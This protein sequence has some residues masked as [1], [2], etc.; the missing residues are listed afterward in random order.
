MD[1]EQAIGEQLKQWGFSVEKIPES[2]VS[3]QKRPDYKAWT[4]TE[5]YLIE[6]KSREDDPEEMQER[7][8]VLNQGDVYSEH[9]PLIRKNRVSGIIRSAYDQL[10]DYGESEWFKVAWLCATGSAQEAKF[11][12]FKATLYGTTQ[13]FDLDGD[14]YHRVCYFFRNS[15][16][17]RYRNVLDAA[18]IST[19]TGGTLCLNPHSPKFEEIRSSALGGKLGSAVIDPVAS[20]S[21]GDAYIVDSG[22]DRNDENAVLEYLRGKYDRP[23][24][25]KIDLGWHSGTVQEPS[26]T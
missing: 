5:T 17:F 8:N 1:I 22:V 25:N 11:E 24:L 2:L 3:G 14:G 23:K 15:E 16:F 21:V 4:D 26:S 6:V 9:K 7:E 19:H 20:E 12:Q 18:L 13:I 10:K